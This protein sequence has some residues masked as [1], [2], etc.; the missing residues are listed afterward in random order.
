MTGK[1]VDVDWAVVQLP[2]EPALVVVE[3]CSVELG[4][5]FGIAKGRVN[6]RCVRRLRFVLLFKFSRSALVLGPDSA[7]GPKIGSKFGSSK[8]GAA[9]VEGKGIRFAVGVPA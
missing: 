6:L 4:V 5:L 8:Y 3:L 9:T 7:P 2:K 1:C